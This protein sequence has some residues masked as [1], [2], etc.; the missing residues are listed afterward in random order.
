L[1]KGKINHEIAVIQNTIK[2]ILIIVPV[3][4]FPHLIVF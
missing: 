3:F 1:N 4:I 2:V